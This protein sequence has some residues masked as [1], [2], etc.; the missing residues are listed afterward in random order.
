VNIIHIDTDSHPA[1]LSDARR[2]VREAMIRA[3]IRVEVAQEMEVAVG[4]ALSNVHRHAYK[5]RVGPVS[6]EVLRTAEAVTVAVA[7]QGG[8]TVAPAVPSTLPART[9]Q[10][11]RGLY[12]VGRL[13]D[14][15]EIQ[16]NRAG[17]GITVRMT[18]R[19]EGKGGEPPP[20]PAQTGSARLG[21]VAPWKTPRW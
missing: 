15:V 18:E 21:G 14:D 17:H 11:G 2:R 7:D 19:L 8:A 6:V 10:G 13:V 20:E 4:E 3:G 5:N 1:A 16:V 12:V 9:D